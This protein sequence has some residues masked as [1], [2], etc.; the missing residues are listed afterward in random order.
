MDGRRKV[1]IS[2]NASWKVTKEICEEIEKNSH[3]SSMDSDKLDTIA[4]RKVG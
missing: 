3:N 1:S 2:E 4:T